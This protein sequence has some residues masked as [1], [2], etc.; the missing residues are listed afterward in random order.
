MKKKLAYILVCGCLIVPIISLQGCNIREPS[1]KPLIDNKA[2]D[3]DKNTTR[4]NKVEKESNK[5]SNSE[6]ILAKDH[7]GSEEVRPENQTEQSISKDNSPIGIWIGY[8]N[9]W[10]ITDNFI[11][12][13]VF[14]VMY[15]DGTIYNDMPIEGQEVFDKDHSRSIEPE[16][17]GI[18]TYDGSSRTGTC[19]ISD[20]D[21]QLF[22]IDEKGNMKVGMTPYY[23]LDPVDELRL[24]GSWTVYA[25]PIDVLDHYG[26]TK[27]I[28]TFTGD[29]MF[30]DEGLFCDGDFYLPEMEEDYIVDEE[31]VAPGEGSYSINDYTLTLNYNDGR[32]RKA[33]FNLYFGEEEKVT[34]DAIFIYRRDLMRLDP[35]LEY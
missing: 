17:W 28:I 25:N 5:Q 8:Q 7:T 31:K 30:I 3:N 11:P 26:E 14:M 2:I 33:S 19:K 35:P 18:Y 29:G 1:E 20:C 6:D 32:V 24:E 34:P 27:P 23:R 22:E 10:A 15:D 16:Y 9:L 21:P 12:M 13:K 4:I